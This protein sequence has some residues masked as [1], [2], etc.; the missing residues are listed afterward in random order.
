ME[1]CPECDS[2]WCPGAVGGYCA[3][4]GGRPTTPKRRKKEG[5]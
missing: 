3:Y 4:I 2:A 5:A 1:H